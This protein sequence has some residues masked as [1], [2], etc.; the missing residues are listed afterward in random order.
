MSKL[1]IAGSITLSY[2]GIGGVAGAGIA[3]ASRPEAMVLGAVAGTVVG[4]V[5]DAGIA[6]AVL[7]GNNLECDS[8]LANAVAAQNYIFGR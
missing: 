3:S 4:A 6:T 5:I 2:A 8:S 1:A 7:T